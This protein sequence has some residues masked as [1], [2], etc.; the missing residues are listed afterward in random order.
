MGKPIG[1]TFLA[2]HDCY[3][4]THQWNKIF[5]YNQ[6][7]PL[8][9][10]VNSTCE[11]SI[12]V[13]SFKCR[14]YDMDSCCLNPENTCKQNEAFIASQK[15]QQLLSASVNSILVFFSWLYSFTLPPEAS[16]VL[17]APATW[18]ISLPQSLSPTEE[19]PITLS[20]KI[21]I[22]FDINRM[23]NSQRTEWSC[24]SPCSYTA[25]SHSPLCH[26]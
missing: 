5:L 25:F 4:K 26:T 16:F 24:S 6:K 10:H 22:S 15:W 19:K 3:K 8:T 14:G 2:M 18:C 11:L 17:E 21:W 7:I 23:M 13:L 20:I 9:L 12:T 1:H